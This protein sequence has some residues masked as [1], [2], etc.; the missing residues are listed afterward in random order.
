MKRDKKPKPLAVCDVCRAITDERADVNHRCTKPYR[1]RRC[2]G[3]FKSGLGIVWNE[4]ESCGATGMV[5]S[6]PC[7]SCAGFGWHLFS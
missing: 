1:G 4:C 5:G 3:I 6:L 7:S 2:Y